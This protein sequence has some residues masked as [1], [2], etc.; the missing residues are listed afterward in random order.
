MK[1]ELLVADSDP[2]VF[3]CFYIAWRTEVTT[4]YY[5]TLLGLLKTTVIYLSFVLK[6]FSKAYRHE[7]TYLCG[8][9]LRK[10]VQCF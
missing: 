1:W 7:I 3:H 9:F 4:F 8:A 10:D 6:F 5:I 2:T